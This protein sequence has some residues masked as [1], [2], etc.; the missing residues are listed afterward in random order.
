M[1]VNISTFCDFS[2]RNREI[3]VNNIV[4]YLFFTGKL[5]VCIKKVL[6]FLKA[7]EWIQPPAAESGGFSYAA[8]AAL[9]APETGTVFVMLDPPPANVP[10]CLVFK[11]KL[12]AELNCDDLT[13]KA[14]IENGDWKKLDD[15]IPIVSDKMNSN[16]AIYRRS[17]L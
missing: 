1:L 9:L 8:V 3:V 10:F 5:P 16:A 13:W 11:C 14:K 17:D 7:V 2:Y 15:V 4:K 12:S 6:A